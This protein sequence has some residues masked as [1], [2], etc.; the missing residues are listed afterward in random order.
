M[1]S[2]VLTVLALLSIE[3]ARAA[4]IET[5][6]AAAAEAATLSWW[7]GCERS[8]DLF[9]DVFDGIFNVTKS[10]ENLGVFRAIV[11]GLSAEERKKGKR[12]KCE[13]KFE[14]VY[15]RQREKSPNIACNVDHLTRSTNSPSC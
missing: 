12:E 6:A 2:S 14:L 3:A 13:F 5:S 4:L 7:S 9:I 11:V 1:R 15:V 10:T 8:V